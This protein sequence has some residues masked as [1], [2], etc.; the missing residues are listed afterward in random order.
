MCPVNLIE[1][2]EID[3]LTGPQF[4]SDFILTEWPFRSKAFYSFKSE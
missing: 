2:F 4:F 1:Y 3:V